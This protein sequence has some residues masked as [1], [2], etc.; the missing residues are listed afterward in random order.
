MTAPTPRARGFTLI[1]LMIAVGL[2]AI[3]VSIA[4][5]GYQS[6]KRKSHRA[7]ARL[8]LTEL[9]AKQEA[10]FIKTRAYATSFAPLYDHPGTT[11][12]LDA[13]GKVSESEQAASLYKLDLT[14]DAG[15]F[16]FAATAIKS[17]AKDEDCKV[18]SVASSGQKLPATDACWTA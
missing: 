1:E 3:L 11:L 18:M 9:A 6:Q 4:I 12:Y 14:T 5:P 10:V 15:S 2:F 13:Q 17:Q 8:V 16:S 7:V